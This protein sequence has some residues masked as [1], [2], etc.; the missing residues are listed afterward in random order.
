MIFI[1]ILNRKPL[2]TVNDEL[3]STAKSTQVSKDK[4]N[5]THPLFKL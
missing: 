5:S 3:N 1:I 2:K 4:N